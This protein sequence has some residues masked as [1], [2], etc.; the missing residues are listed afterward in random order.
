MFHL[1]YIL[2]LINFV[3]TLELCVGCQVMLLVNLDI[4]RG[5]V[6][7]SRG[8][9]TKF[10]DGIP[11]VKFLNGEDIL[12]DTYKWDI[13]DNDKLIGSVNQIPLRLGYALTIHKSQGSTLDL[14]Q[15]NLSD[16]F[17]YGMVYVALSRIK[18]LDGLIIESI[19]YNKIKC[20]PKVKQFYLNYM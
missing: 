18:S 20:N 2:Y 5:L 13:M 12:V 9:I 17:E 19:D 11:L 14:V 8:I 1:R 10:V 3:R 4:K 6:N 15:V 16:V 7:G